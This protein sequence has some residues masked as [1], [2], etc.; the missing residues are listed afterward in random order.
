MAGILERIE[1]AK[2]PPLYTMS[3]AQ[4]RLA[5]VERS[6]V[7]ELPRAPLARVEDLAIPADDGTPLAAR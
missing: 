1:R 3:P 7:L 5:Y 6:E 4:A 2:A